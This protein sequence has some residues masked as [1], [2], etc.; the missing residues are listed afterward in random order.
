M[1][2]S[3][4]LSLRHFILDSVLVPVLTVLAHTVA[5]AATEPVRGI[6]FD[7]NLANPPVLT[8]ELM[9]QQLPSLGVPLNVR[10]IVQRG[11]VERH[12]GEYDFNALDARVGLYASLV[13]T[14]GAMAMVLLVPTR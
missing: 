3:L 10:L 8:Q 14:Q 12:P 5:F 11:E 9:D 1:K 6:G 2:K 13:Y 4:S 7:E